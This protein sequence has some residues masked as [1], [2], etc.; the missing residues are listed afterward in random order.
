LVGRA[1]RER[2][3]GAGL[4]IINKKKKRKGKKVTS[5][6]G[7]E[8]ERKQLKR[9]RINYSRFFGI[10]GIEVEVFVDAAALFL[11]QRWRKLRKV[12]WKHARSRVIKKERERERRER[13][14]RNGRR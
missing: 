10:W 3:E 5:D 8:K 13:E 4:L 6:R 9:K 7:E 14:T 12:F 1:E 2:E 11:L